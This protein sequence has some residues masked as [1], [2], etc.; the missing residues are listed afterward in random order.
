MLIASDLGKAPPPPIQ[1]HPP[2]RAPKD[3]LSLLLSI[4]FLQPIQGPS[5]TAARKACQLPQ[6]NQANIHFP[7]VHQLKCVLMPTCALAPYLILIFNVSQ[8]LNLL[9]RLRIRFSLPPQSFTS[10]PTSLHPSAATDRS[11]GDSESQPEIRAD[12]LR[13]GI[14]AGDTHNGCMGVYDEGSK[15]LDA[16]NTLPVDFEE[17]M[18]DEDFMETS[19]PR[20]TTNGTYLFTMDELQADSP[21]VDVSL[22]SPPLRDHK[23]DFGESPLNGYDTNCLAGSFRNQSTHQNPTPH[24]YEISARQNGSE[25]AGGCSE[26]ST[27][28]KRISVEV[29]SERLPPKRL[30]TDQCSKSPSPGT[31]DSP[32]GDFSTHF[33]ATNMIPINSAIISPDEYHQGANNTSQVIQLANTGT[34]DQGAF[35]IR[36][37]CPLNLRSAQTHSVSADENGVKQK[38][39]RSVRQKP[40]VAVES[41]GPDSIPTKPTLS[42]SHKPP[43]QR[44]KPRK[45]RG[46]PAKKTSIAKATPRDNE[47][48]FTSLRSLFLSRPFDMRLQFISWLF[49][50]VLPRCMH[51]SK[52]VTNSPSQASGMHNRIDH[53]ARATCAL[54]SMEAIHI[55]AVGDNLGY[56]ASNLLPPTSNLTIAQHYCHFLSAN[57]KGLDSRICAPG[58]SGQNVCIGS[59]RKESRS[60]V[61]WK[62]FELP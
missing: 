50:A 21:Y 31:V 15:T 3:P 7:L 20:Q 48:K 58:I 52:A 28:C 10:H 26:K 14:L 46:R 47:Y 16:P 37:S 54:Y 55:V 32:L 6:I 24:D 8:V 2:P 1:A 43:A 45:P 35:R 12:I 60:V 57:T 41:D 62:G 49:E 36:R 34:S 44:I 22:D 18:F 23:Q 51:D 27:A 19:Q 59:D 33:D 30:K 38:L 4:L 53:T 25:E 42:N 13:D 5:V 56:L 40:Q 11:K 39:R 29:E 9:S 17:T 61:R